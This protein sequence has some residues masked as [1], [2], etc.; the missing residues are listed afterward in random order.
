MKTT[1]GGIV[2]PQ[3]PFRDLV[4]GD[5]FRVAWNGKVDNYM[6]LDLARAAPDSK[7]PW[8]YRASAN[9]ETGETVWLA[10]NQMVGLPT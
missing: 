8:D 1:F 3:Q 9:I 4:P 2:K 7:K 6:T 5:T 10:D